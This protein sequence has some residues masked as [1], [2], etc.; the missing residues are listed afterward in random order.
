METLVDSFCER[1]A[2]FCTFTL[3]FDAGDVYEIY[4]AF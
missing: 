1:Q 4:E 2:S 3:E